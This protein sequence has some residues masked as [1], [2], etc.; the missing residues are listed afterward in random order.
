MTVSELIDLLSDY[1]ENAEVRLAHQP[2]WPFEY[3]VQAVAGAEE[4]WELE[5]WNGVAG[6]EAEDEAP[7]IVYIAEG[8]QLGYLPGFARAVWGIK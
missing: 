5:A 4:M 2:H 8:T 7:N 1:P 3:S 6:D